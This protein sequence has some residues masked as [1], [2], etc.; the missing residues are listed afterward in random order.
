[1][2]RRHFGTQGPTARV[3]CE[4]VVGSVYNFVHDE[5]VAG[6]DTGAAR[7]W[8]SEIRRAKLTKSLPAR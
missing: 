3:Y 4:A 1:M 6:D 8:K 5:A 2:I 7:D